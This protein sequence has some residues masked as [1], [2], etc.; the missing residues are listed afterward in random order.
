MLEQYKKIDLIRDYVVRKEAEINNYNSQKNI[1]K[2][3]LANGRNLTNVGIFR[4]YLS[5]Y[6][7][8][9]PKVNKELTMMVRQLPPTDKG[10]PLEIYCFTLDKEW[11]D[12]ETIAADIFD[13]VL[14]TVPSFN[15]EIFEGPT[16]K[17][18]QGSFSAA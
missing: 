17:D 9:H 2:S 6:I 10:L 14:A 4:E 18:F 11:V 7:Q 13:H 15:L 3:I 1:D 5:N 12:H 8:K 16:G